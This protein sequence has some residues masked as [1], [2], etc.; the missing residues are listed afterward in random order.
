MLNQC[1]IKSIVEKEERLLERFSDEVICPFSVQPFGIESV[2]VLQSILQQL[3]SYF[4]ACVIKES[5][6]QWF[7]SYCKQCFS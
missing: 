6:N 3:F 4:D 2:Q 1:W 5:T 7:L